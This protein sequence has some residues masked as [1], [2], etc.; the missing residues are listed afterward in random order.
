MPAVSPAFQLCALLRELRALPFSHLAPDSAADIE[1]C[2]REVATAQGID[3]TPCTPL[4][5]PSVGARR[6]ADAP[7]H[8]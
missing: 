7:R 3:L 5:G 6:A 4:A 8:R 1:A 2:T